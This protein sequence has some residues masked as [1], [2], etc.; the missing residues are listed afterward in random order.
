MK[1]SLVI[2]GLALALLVAGVAGYRQYIVSN[3]QERVLARLNDPDSAKFRNIRLFSDWTPANS[4]LCGEVNAR[5]R[6]GGYV[7]YRE[8]FLMGDTGYVFIDDD[9]GFESSFTTTRKSYCPF[10]NRTKWWHLR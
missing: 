8:F 6:L 1:K 3:L 2:G 4:S 5:N 9:P 7:G 10:G